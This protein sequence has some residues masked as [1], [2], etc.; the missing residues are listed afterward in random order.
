MS[1]WQ[2][3]KEQV[4]ETARRMLAEG[5]VVGT[6][7]N[8]SL[9][10]P[11]YE[12]REILAITPH[13]IYYDLMTPD[14]I[15]IIDFEGEPLEGEIPSAEAMLH[16]SIYQARSKVKA[17][18]HTHSVFASALAAAG[19]SLPAILDEQVTYIGGEV[20]L[21]K[22][23]ISGSQELA[24]NVVQALGQRNAVLLPNH[25]MVGVGRS[26]RE[27]LT[28]CQLVER[29]AQ[30]FLLSQNLGGAIPLPPEVVEAEQS[31]FE[32]LQSGEE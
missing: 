29:T 10:L 27:A 26:L 20:R 17:V 28:V 7:G 23:A 16:I 14:D 12:G 6:S 4:L 18:I 31:F 32:M 11:P 9:R 30:I 2:K 13:H 25:G 1:Q 3:E 19:Q 21:A 22:Y 8:V 5:L 15:V 24:D